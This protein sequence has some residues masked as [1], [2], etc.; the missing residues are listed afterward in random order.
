MRISLFDEQELKALEDVLARALV[1]AAKTIMRDMDLFRDEQ[2]TAKPGERAAAN[3]IAGAQP[4]S[5]PIPV[6]RPEPAPVQPPELK[7]APPP[8][9]KP[10]RDPDWEQFGKVRA[11]PPAPE[12]VPEPPAAAAVENVPVNEFV[13]DVAI[14]EDDE[15]APAIPGKRR[16][17]RDVLRSVRGKPEGYITVDMA[18]RDIVGVDSAAQSALSKWMMEGEVEAVIAYNTG[19]TPTKGMSGGRV[20]VKAEDVRRRQQERVENLQ[21]LPALRRWRERDGKHSSAAA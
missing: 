1:R 15:R 9:P 10:V 7:K 11:A 21:K 20:M 12:P 16:S 13:T 17:L 8:P 19:L 3:G 6:V 4:S 2:R 14:E 5:E 18:R